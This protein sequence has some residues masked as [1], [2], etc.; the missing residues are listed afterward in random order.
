MTTA[1]RCF[2]PFCRREIPTLTGEAR[3]PKF[4]ADCAQRARRLAKVGKDVGLK[5]GA[6]ALG[7]TLERTHPVAFGA[8]RDAYHGWKRAAAEAEQD[9]TRTIT[10]EVIDHR[11][12]AS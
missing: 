6:R 4:C 3:P 7:R 5:T 2:N 8:A 1:A 10:V 11:K 12:A 9:D